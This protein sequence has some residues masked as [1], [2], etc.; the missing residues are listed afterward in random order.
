MGRNGKDSTYR[1]P[2]LIAAANGYI[3]VLR[4]FNRRKTNNRYIRKFR[5]IPNTT[6]NGYNSENLTA[7]IPKSSYYRVRNDLSNE[8][9]M[10]KLYIDSK[11]VPRYFIT[12]KG[13]SYLTGTIKNE[14]LKTACIN[15]RPN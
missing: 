3:R 7:K 6:Q 2:I 9:F 15:Y 13:F 14:D 12:L 8:G 1:L 5:A 11:H 4:S 10:M